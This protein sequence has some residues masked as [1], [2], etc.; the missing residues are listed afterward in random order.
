MALAPQSSTLSPGNVHYL[1]PPPSPPI[2]LLLIYLHVYVGLDRVWTQRIWA[3]NAMPT[4][5]TLEAC[6]LQCRNSLPP[7]RIGSCRHLGAMFAK[8]RAR[9]RWPAWTASHPVRRMDVICDIGV[10]FTL[11]TYSL[12]MLVFGS[13]WEPV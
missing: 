13:G 11:S 2:T 4:C 1:D 10:S 7:C 9:S 5:T 6:P 3:A 12:K 8:P